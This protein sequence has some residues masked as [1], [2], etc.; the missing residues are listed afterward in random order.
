MTRKR[1]ALFG[2]LHHKYFYQF[3]YSISEGLRLISNSAH[4]TQLLCEFHNYT[5]N[6]T[7]IVGYS[8]SH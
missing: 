3:H 7:L 8:N 6:F 5:S 1:Y 2:I 4:N